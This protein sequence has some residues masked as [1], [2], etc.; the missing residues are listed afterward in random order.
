METAPRENTYYFNADIK[1]FSKK[2]PKTAKIKIE[3]WDD[4]SGFFGSSDDL[5]LRAED[6]VDSFLKNGMKKGAVISSSTNAVDTISFW[7]NEYVYL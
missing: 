5:I 6:S 7:Q 2:I 3:V 4:D 1:Y